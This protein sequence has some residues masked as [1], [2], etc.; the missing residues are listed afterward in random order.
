MLINIF[1][2]LLLL[3]CST[4]I[5]KKLFNLPRNIYLLFMAQPLVASSAP[6]IVFIG[7]LL[8]SQIASDPSLATLPITLLILGVA[9]ASVPAALIAIT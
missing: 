2:T 5:L 6:I 7:G 9:M 4:W 1:I 3:V 8:S